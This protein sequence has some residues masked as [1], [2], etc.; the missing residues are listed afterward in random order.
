M[1]GV[2]GL[3]LVS[4]RNQEAGTPR[5]LDRLRLFVLRQ[6]VG[7]DRDLRTAIGVLD[8]DLAAYLGQRGRTLGVPGLEDLDDARK[9]VRDVGAGDTPRM[10]GPHR[11]LRSG[12]ADRL[13]R[14]DADRVADLG[15]LAGGKERAVARPA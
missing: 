9:T 15:G 7:D 10:E 12:L 4:L 1:Q 5:Q 6:V 3:H 14:D 11:Q 8:V 2:A 13:G